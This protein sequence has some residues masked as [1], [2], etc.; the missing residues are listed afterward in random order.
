M[1]RSI[2]FASALCA[3]LFVCVSFVRAEDSRSRLQRFD[4][5]IESLNASSD[6]RA[7]VL[8]VIY[9]ELRGPDTLEMQETLR[10]ALSRSN[11]LILQGVVEALAM[12]GDARDVGNLETFLAVSGKMDAKLLTIRLLPAF[13]LGHSERARFNFIRHAAGYDRVAAPGVL[14]PLRRPPLSRRGRLEP[15]REDLRN[16]VTRALARQFDPVADALRYLDDRIHGPA[17][18][19]VVAHYVGNALGAD[20]SRWRQI[21]AAQGSDVPLLVPD[22]V[23]ELRLAALLSLSDMGAEGL[24]EVVE[25]LRALFERGGET[26]RQ[27]A[28]D[29]SAVMCRVGF[30]QFEALRSMKFDVEDAAG[31]GGWR[32][33]RHASSVNLAV[34]I[35][36]AALAG[37]FAPEAD[38]SV[39]VA[40]ADA[41]GAAL[42]YPA[43]FPDPDGRLGA[44][45]L[46]G[47]EG[48]ER[49]LFMPDMSQRKRS[50]VVLALGELGAARGVDAIAGILDSPYASPEY[51]PEGIRLAESAVDALRDVAAG[52][53]EGR[54]A[55]RGKL[56]LLL[57]DARAYPSRRAD[58]P[59]TGLAHM[60]LWRLQRL[61][62][63][64]D[65]SLDAE[66]WRKRLGW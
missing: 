65:S 25:A 64:N 48:L 21:W 61:A 5:L 60:A 42:S 26:L 28:F 37:L 38:A 52:D 35:A 49:L 36:G 14:E 17:A 10:D 18:R 16:R 30:G 44:A 4:G 51:G 66:L 40:A 15:A 24:P 39:F 22:E 57:S 2:R 63:S 27:A 13:C 54:D 56:L 6:R 45:R 11:T 41:L 59:P 62:R 34:F 33:R 43:D 3:C 31:A 7:G 19:A 8:D 46:E 55:A 58:A 20:P 23:E 29:A 9:N 12:F 47:L 1:I 53:R 32:D 50:A